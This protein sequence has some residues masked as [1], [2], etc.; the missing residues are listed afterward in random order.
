[1]PHHWVNIGAFPVS[2]YTGTPQISIPIWEIQDGDISVPVSLNYHTGGIQVQEIA[3]WV[4]LGWALNGG[5]VISR[6]VR[7]LPDDLNWGFLD[8]SNPVPLTYDGSTL[9][10][11]R[12]IN[13]AAGFKDCQ[14]DLFSLN[15]SGKNGKFQMGQDRTIYLQ[16]FQK[17]K[18][19]PSPSTGPI[20]KWTVTAENGFIYEFDILETSRSQNYCTGIGNT[21]PGQIYTS[22]W[23]LSKITS[24]K[25]AIVTLEYDTG[26][27]LYYPISSF[28]NKYAQA[29][30]SGGG[31]PNDLSCTTYND[32]RSGVRLKKIKCATTEVEFVATENR[33]DL[34]GDKRLNYITIKDYKSNIIRKFKFGY[35]YMLDNTLVD[36]PAYGYINDDAI[37]YRLAL[38]SLQETDPNESMSKP[39]YQFFYKTG[40]P[41]RLSCA[42]DIWG[43]YNGQTQNTTMI[44]EEFI[45]GYTVF[46][47]TGGAMH[48]YDVLDYFRGAGVSTPT[49]SGTQSLH[50]EGGNR[51]PYNGF[52]NAGAITKIKY[53]TGGET[54]FEFELNTANQGIP[55][56]KEE[57]PPK[58]Y[59]RF[60]V[61]RP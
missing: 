46:D 6:S 51:L 53:P 58:L 24:P 12:F 60:L 32:V 9:A 41:N 34:P 3:S 13:Y 17:L 47:P 2:L 15:F 25:G 20:T 1:M 54:N 8:P 35:K 23:Y 61:G 59:Q 18:I 52:V 16:P 36:A 37:K 26:Y 7:G 44:Q 30:Y 27:T 45:K 40:L 33:Y 42:V 43:Y 49:V 4:G 28:E 38:V 5:G 22:S 48:W 50:L 29:V 39:P 55:Q 31:V 21:P 14:P 56:F 10:N 11:E 57:D 19:V